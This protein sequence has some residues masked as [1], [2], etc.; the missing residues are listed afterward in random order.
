MRPSTTQQS[1]G[2]HPEHNQ[3]ENND[4]IDEQF[5]QADVSHP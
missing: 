4:T 5:N 2:A 3:D 1:H